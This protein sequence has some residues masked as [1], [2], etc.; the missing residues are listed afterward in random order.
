M[1]QG[2]KL[3]YRDQYSSHT[4]VIARIRYGGWETS[5]KIKEDKN[6]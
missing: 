2:V 1:Q 3:A 5:F 6:S 4:S